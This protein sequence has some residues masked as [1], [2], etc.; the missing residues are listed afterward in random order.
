M[1]PVYMTICHK[2]LRRPKHRASLSYCRDEVWREEPEEEKIFSLVQAR[3]KGAHFRAMDSDSDDLYD[4]SDSVPIGG[5][6]KPE[7]AEAKMEDVDEG[8]EEGEEI[9][10]DDSDDVSCLSEL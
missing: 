5:Q 8:E 7:N 6:Y 2:F 1:L 3:A 4:P 9:E 10:E